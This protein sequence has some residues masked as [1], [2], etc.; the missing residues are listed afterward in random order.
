MHWG[1]WGFQFCRD[2][3]GFGGPRPLQNEELATDSARGFLY[4]IR[5]P[6]TLFLVHFY[7]FQ[8]HW[9]LQSGKPGMGKHVGRMATWNKENPQKSKIHFVK[10]WCERTLVYPE[11]HEIYKKQFCRGNSCSTFPFF[12][13]INITR[14]NLCTWMLTN[15]KAST[16]WGTYSFSHLQHASKCPH[17]K[18]RNLSLHILA[19]T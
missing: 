17:Y 9:P 7:E 18:I 15:P 10:G 6:N 3:S 8:N 5:V 1:G 14:S 13:K 11:N 16:A 19:D 2:K 12:C 4:K